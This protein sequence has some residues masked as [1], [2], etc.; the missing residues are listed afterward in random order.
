MKNDFQ[1]LMVC[2]ANICRSPMAEGIMRNKLKERNIDAKVDSAGT[3]DWQVGKNPDQRAILTMMEHH[4][5]ISKLVARQ[6]SKNDFY[7]FD[8]ILAMDEQNYQDI[9]LMADNE[10]HKDKVK[11]I[12]SYSSHFSHTISVPDPW[13]GK[14]RG[15]EEIYQ[16]LDK[17]CEEVIK[18]H[19]I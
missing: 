10:Q 15:F 13:Y 11:L 8:L 12:L 19:F 3:S 2:L 17:A 18:T 4:I 7:H 1:I 16:L 9:I 6:F 14:Q 5:N